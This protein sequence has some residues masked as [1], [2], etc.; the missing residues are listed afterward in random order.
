MGFKICIGFYEQKSDSVVL[1]CTTTTVD[2]NFGALYV[3]GSVYDTY[4]SW[5]TPRKHVGVQA[6]AMA[7]IDGSVSQELRVATTELE[8]TRKDSLAHKTAADRWVPLV[9]REEGR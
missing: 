6:I 4:I 7:A 8:T 3:A 5:E 2:D 9:L 1:A